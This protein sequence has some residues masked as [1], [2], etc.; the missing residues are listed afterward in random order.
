MP[1]LDAEIY[2]HEIDGREIGDLLMSEVVPLAAKKRRDAERYMRIAAAMKAE[3]QE[4]YRRLAE[5]AME[6]SRLLQQIAD[7]YYRP[8]G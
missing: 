1:R 6:D 7:D 4:R 5:Q 8:A 2:A 3:D